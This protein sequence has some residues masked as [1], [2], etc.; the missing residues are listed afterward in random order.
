MLKQAMRSRIIPLTSQVAT[1]IVIAVCVVAVG[2]AQDPSDAVES[3]LQVFNASNSTIQLIWDQSTEEKPTATIQSGRNQT[4][5]TFVGHTHWI[6]DSAG[7]RL[8]S[9]TSK[10]PVQAFR[11]QDAGQEDLATASS[12]YPQNKVLQVE[13][14][15]NVPAFYEKV[16]FANGF[17]IVGSDGVDDHALLEAAFLINQLLAK[18]E[19]VRK[20]MIASGSRMCV[21]SEDEFTTDLPEFRWLGRR[22]PIPGIEGRDYWDARA[23]GLGGSDTDPY[24]SCGEENLLNFKGDPYSTENILIHEF[25]HNIHLRGLANID[26]TFDKRLKQA[27]QFA[28]DSGLWK[29]KYASV[30]HHEYFAEGVQSWFNNNRENDHDHNHVNTRVELKEYDAKLASLCEEV[31]GETEFRYTK[32]GTRLNGHLADYQPDPEVKFQWPKR[33]EMAKK[34]IYRQATQREGNSGATTPK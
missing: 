21:M 7:N 3:R 19:D 34:E 28:M 17:P 8:T 12:S 33:L 31:F 23:R 22:S 16:V 24:C 29:G 32:T 27:Y 4:I 10:M 15:M 30:N 20:A 6:V 14:K 25:A 18:R 13:P 2:H 9:I 11:Y 26:P 1:F 5:R